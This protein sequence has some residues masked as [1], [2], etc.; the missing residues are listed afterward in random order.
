RAAGGEPGD[1]AGVGEALLRGGEGGEGQGVERAGDVYADAGA[2]ARAGLAVRPPSVAYT[3]GMRLYSVGHGA[4][5]LED[6]VRTLAAADVGTVVD[7][8]SHPGSRRHPHFAREALTQSLPAH[9]IQYLW[10]PRLGGRRP[11]GPQPSPNP[12]LLVEGFRNYADYMDT[13][14]FAA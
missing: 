9:N 5:P 12:S 8:R 10:E 13:D 14:E 2:V 11:R 1:A 4:R 6:L 7:V 3:V